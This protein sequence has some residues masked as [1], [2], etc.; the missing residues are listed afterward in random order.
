MTPDTAAAARTAATKHGVPLAN[1][2]ACIE[3]E[4]NGVV[5]ATVHG[6]Q[7][8]IVRWEGHY[9]D[10]LIVNGKRAEARRLG[11]AAS[12]AGA[13]KNPSG[14]QDRWDKLITP[15]CAL[16]ETAALKSVSW[17]VGQVM[18]ANAES[19]GYANV[20]EMVSLARSGVAGQI[21]VMMAFVVKNNLVPPLQRGDFSAF[22]RVYNGPA[23]VADYASKMT[24]LALEYAQI[25][26]Q[27][28]V[29]VA[30]APT[31]SARATATAASMVRPGVTGAK[32]REVQ[33]LLMRAGFAVNVDGDFGKATDKAVRAFQKSR[34]LEEDGLVGPATWTALEEYKAAPEEHPGVPTVAG[35]AT[36]TVKGRQGTTAVGGGL[37][38]TAVVQSA[39]EGLA[40]VLHTSQWVDHVY[41]VLTVAGVVVALVG[42][43]WV[44]YGW[45]RAQHTRGLSDE[46]R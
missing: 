39:K 42:V 13:V 22:A 2:L 34:G 41:A 16:D 10:R 45:Y 43:A 37:T 38:L 25:Y 4:S 35:A 15:A 31:A 8:P 17:G 24:K 7:E 30:D 12:K 18:G 3:V 32:V 46:A 44:G 28:V 33:T 21:A 19:I 9:F 5:F 29:A 14:Q 36:Q 11:L 26:P 27:G 40:P 20:Q 6:R 23:N 1:L